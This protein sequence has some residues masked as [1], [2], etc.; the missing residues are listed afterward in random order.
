VAALLVIG[1]V[2]EFTGIVLLG[3]PDFLP[4]AIR[5]SAWLRRQGRRAANLLRRLVGKPPRG[6]V[7]KVGLDAAVGVEVS[8]SAVVGTGATTLEGQVEYLLRR[9]QDAQRQANEFASRLNRLEAESPRRLAEV[10]QDMEKHVSAEL[11]ASMEAYRPLRIV[12]TV[13]L[14]VG[15]LC[16]TLATFLA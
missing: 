15:L 9:D 5:V 14:A 16:V 10:R 2:S 3:F 7:H 6:S 4:G 11:T 8:A 13:A 12:G 1:A